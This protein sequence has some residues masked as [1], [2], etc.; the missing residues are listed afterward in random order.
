MSP[1]SAWPH[2]ALGIAPGYPELNS[3]PRQPES[4]SQIWAALFPGPIL[5]KSDHSYVVVP[6]LNCLQG[7]QTELRCARWDTHCVHAVTLA[8]WV[9]ARNGKGKRGSL[10]AGGPCQLSRKYHILRTQRRLRI[11]I[12]VQASRC[13]WRYICAGWRKNIFYLRVY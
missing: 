12:S 11:P 7:L 2:P 10:E 4:A 3:S 6:G 5:Q 13:L 8:V 9:R 1:L